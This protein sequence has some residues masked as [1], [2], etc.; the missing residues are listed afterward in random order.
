MISCVGVEEVEIGNPLKLL[1]KVEK[2]LQDMINCMIN[3]LRDIARKSFKNK[4]TFD[5]KKWIE[6][7]PA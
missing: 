5:R 2:Y 7:D 6:T 1:D 4:E 3:T